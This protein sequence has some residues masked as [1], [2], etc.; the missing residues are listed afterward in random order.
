MLLLVKIMS[1]VSFQVQFSPIHLTLFNRAPLSAPWDR[2]A[3]GPIHTTVSCCGICSVRSKLKTHRRGI[4]SL[5]FL[6]WT[7]EAVQRLVD[8]KIPT[9][10]KLIEL[11]PAGTIDPDAILVQQ[12]VLHV[13]SAYECGHREQPGNLD[14]RF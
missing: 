6:F 8:A 11:A 2:P 4:A 1:N 12:D 14:A 9:I 7:K 13:G 10:K 5:E 3:S